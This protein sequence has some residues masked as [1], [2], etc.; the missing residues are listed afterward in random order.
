[1]IKWGHIVQAERS[2]SLAQDEETSVQDSQD[3]DDDMNP[4]VTGTPLPDN[5]VC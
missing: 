1:M 4:S 3:S 5:L 2:N